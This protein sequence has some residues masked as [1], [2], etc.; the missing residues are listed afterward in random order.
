MAMR[1]TEATPLM[2]VV[3]AGVIGNV[4]EWYDFAL[5]GYFA[6][7]IGAQFFPSSDP[8]NSLLAAFVAFAAGF[9]LRPLGGVVLGRLADQAGHRASLL[10]S[11]LGMA[12]ATVLIAVLPG[13]SRIGL[14]APVL[15]VLL[16]LFQGLSAGGEYTTSIV[17]L[18]EHAHDKKRVFSV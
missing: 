10:I 17:F 2:G 14:M 8:R 3:L 13:Y 12:T 9:L 15:M 5:Y 7:E 16:R 4:M 18:C 11:V 1:S 6:T